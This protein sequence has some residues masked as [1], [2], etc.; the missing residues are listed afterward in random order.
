M[1]IE[2]RCPSCAKVGYIEVSE[3]I[4]KDVNRGLLAVNVA[5]SIVCEHSFVA[6][7]DKNLKIRDCFMADF[8]I[9]IP[10]LVSAEPAEP[11]KEKKVDQIDLVLLKLN[12]PASLIAYILR[13]IFLK[14]S[15]IILSD[16]N[17]IYD[18]VI[19][20]F[21][22]ITEGSY[23]FDIT[24]LPR[25]DYISNKK[26]YKGSLIF[27]GNEIIQDKE[28]LIKSKDLKVE[29]TIVE[30]FLS[31]YD[32]RSSLIILRNE[33]KKSYTLAQSIVDYVNNFE[34]KEVQSKK[35]LDYLAEKHNIEIKI[36]YLKF[37]TNIVEN[38]FDVEVPI[39]SEIGN[40]LGFL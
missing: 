18:H 10:E 36:P 39:S 35:I 31:E 29:R 34:G 15:I 13:G 40:F 38:Y 21:E 5:E 19:N 12:L 9:E 20:L 27:E 16:Q 23:E 24:L 26:K 8:H 22:Y 3:E 7:V 6:Y 30:R 25:E 4:L 1:K 32:L 28:K 33:I 2:V 17:Y 14:Q 11:K 37:L